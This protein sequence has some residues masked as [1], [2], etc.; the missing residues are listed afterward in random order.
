MVLRV[1]RYTKVTL[2]PSA[3]ESTTTTWAIRD[4]SRESEQLSFIRN[5][6]QQRLEQQKLDCSVRLHLVCEGIVFDHWLTGVRFISHRSEVNKPQTQ[7]DVRSREA[8]FLIA[9]VSKTETPMPEV[10][11]L[12]TNT[13]ITGDEALIH[14]STLQTVQNLYSLYQTTTY[15]EDEASLYFYGLHLRLTTK[16]S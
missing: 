7:S 6:C 5:A 9:K 13:S 1:P 4:F 15:D 14:S 10:A 8:C 3:L 12:K 2:S 16:S 11:L